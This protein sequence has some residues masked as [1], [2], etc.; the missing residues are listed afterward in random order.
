MK[1]CL[2][3]VFLCICSCSSNDERKVVNDFFDLYSEYS[4]DN[5][6]V[7]IER[8]T[9]NEYVNNFNC[10]PNGKSIKNG[11]PE[12]SLLSQCQYILSISSDGCHYTVLNALSCESGVCE[13]IYEFYG[14]NV[15][16]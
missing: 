1:A 11:C 4:R 13:N 3:F 5:T 2:V 7:K 16:N 6:E 8:C 10:A 14:V 12:Q 9:H 15:C